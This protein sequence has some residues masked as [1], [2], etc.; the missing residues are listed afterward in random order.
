M[1]DHLQPEPVLLGGWF[2]LLC[3]VF[4]PWFSYDTGIETR[5]RGFGDAD[6]RYGLL[7]IVLLV[8][9]LAASLLARR[10]VG[11]ALAAAGL[12]VATTTAIIVLVGHSM[13]TYGADRDELAVSG[14]LYLLAVAA[15]LVA[16]GA[17]R[18]AIEA[19]AEETGSASFRS[20]ARAIERAKEEMLKEFELRQRAASDP[21]RT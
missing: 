3:A 11:T 14:G 8:L 17:L 2:F 12:G 16:A 13:V 7:L 4:M 19:S 21:G 15:G 5:S 10:N 18:A 9:T 1:S 20:T 6:G